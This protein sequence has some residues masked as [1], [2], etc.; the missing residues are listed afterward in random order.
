MKIGNRKVKLAISLAIVT[1]ISMGTVSANAA[2]MA[3]K[4]VNLSGYTLTVADAGGLFKVMCAAYSCDAGAKYKINW[5]TFATGPE[6]LAAT[7]G[8]SVQ[9]SSTAMAPAV[10]AA[11]AKQPVKIVAVTAPQRKPGALF[12][13]VVS[14]KSFDAGVTT[15]AGLRGKSLAMTLGTESEYLA[16]VALKKA[17]VPLT[18]VAF[19]N[20]APFAAFSALNTGAVG[21]AV[22]VEPFLS[23]AKAAGAQVLATGNGNLAGYFAFWQST[24]AMKNPKVVAATNDL[25]VRWQKMYK[26]F[27]VDRTG[28]I[29]IFS[30]TFFPTYP[31]AVA[32]PLA[33]VLYDGSVAGFVP[34]DKVIIKAFQDEADVMYQVGNVNRKIN[35]TNW[36]DA[37]LYEKTLKAL[38]K[39]K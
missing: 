23:M 28:G 8:G 39:V 24:K 19:N 10:F 11:A 18:S 29:A 5:V 14:K 17:K 16:I 38:P 6:A 22:L 12:S 20:L 21:A 7:V 15:M 35:M 1:A 2:S 37:K 13:V 3:P 34:I 9:F 4:A 31:A 27:S 30:K 32:T 33:T 26:Q 36:F 25:L